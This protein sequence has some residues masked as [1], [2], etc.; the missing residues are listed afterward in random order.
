MVH[1]LFACMTR[2][3]A[4]PTWPRFRPWRAACGL[5]QKPLLAVLSLEEGLQPL[6]ADRV[7]LLDCEACLA[8]RCLEGLDREALGDGREVGAD[9]CLLGSF[10]QRRSEDL[11]DEDGSS[12]GQH[13]AALPKGSTDVLDVSHHVLREHDIHGVGVERDLDS[14][15]FETLLWLPRFLTRKDDRDQ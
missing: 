8:C 14:A 9:A 3:G 4:T 12:W 5:L 11:M 7:H 2:N 10:E 1:R 13:P 6:R 15:G